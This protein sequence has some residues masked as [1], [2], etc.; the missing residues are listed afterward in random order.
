MTLPK[1]PP[2]TELTM[3]LSTRR[4]ELPFDE[5]VRPPLADV[6]TVVSLSP[7]TGR[8]VSACY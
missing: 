6:R 5:V 1:L 8:I 3:S 2:R 7:A 4:S